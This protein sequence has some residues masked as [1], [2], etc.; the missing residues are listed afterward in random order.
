MMNT[1]W[2]NWQ[3]ALGEITAEYEAKRD[4]AEGYM[5]LN[6]SL[7]IRFEPLDRF[8]AMITDWADYDVVDPKLF[9][10]LKEALE[11]VSNVDCEEFVDEQWEEFQKMI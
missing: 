1:E 8:Y 4:W 9:G 10:S 3:T 5:R 6:F 11:Y 2:N 7:R